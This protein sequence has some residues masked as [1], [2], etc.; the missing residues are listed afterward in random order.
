MYV[1][2]MYRIYRYTPT[3]VKQSAKYT[4]GTGTAHYQKSNTF[5]QCFYLFVRIFLFCAY[6]ILQYKHNIRS[7]LS[8]IYFICT[9]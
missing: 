2:L 5:F 6:M 9:R 1:Y 3:Y 4:S 8:N 7:L